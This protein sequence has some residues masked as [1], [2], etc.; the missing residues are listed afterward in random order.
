MNGTTQTRRAVLTIATG[1]RV[2]IDMAIA[3]ARSFLHWHRESDIEFH[4]AT[5]FTGDFP[6]DLQPITI[7][8]HQPGELGV[9]FSMKLKLDQLARARQTLF[10]DADCLCIGPL[11]D[12]FERF[13]GC[14]V[15]VVGDPVSEGEWFGDIERTRTQFGLASIPKF[16]GGVY[17]LE[18]GGVASKVYERARE[19]E[20]RYDDIGLVRLRDCP[21]EELLMSIALAEAGCPPL[22]DDGSIHGDLFAHPVLE[23][24]DVARGVAVL[25]NPAPGEPHHRDHYPSRTIRPKVVHFLGDFTSKWPYQGQA[26]ELEMIAAGFSPSLARCWVS[27]TFRA[28]ARVRERLL[29]LVRPAY[30][31]I[32]G[33]RAVRYEERF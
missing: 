16:N 3:L 33:A 1:K 26:R 6:E 22:H 15:S 12:V 9:G 19:L 32:F 21:N 13:A 7:L 31:R 4:L 25:R 27:L 5:D 23:R 28:P 20:S 11:D 17:Y 24:V 2:Y 10:I 18:P 8:R 30:H 14:D 29:D